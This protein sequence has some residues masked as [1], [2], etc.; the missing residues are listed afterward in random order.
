MNDWREKIPAFWKG[1]G[2]VILV[3]LLGA[4]LLLL[5]DRNTADEVIPEQN[6]QVEF[7]LA[8][9]EQRLSQALS[10]V[11]GAGETRVVLSLDSG[12]RTIL[13]QDRQQ[14]EGGATVETVTLG[15]RSGG[16]AV[17]PVQTMAPNFRGAVV[18][19]P[20]AE[21]PS[22]RLA[23]TRAVSVLTGLGADRICVCAGN[24]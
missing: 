17:V 2:P 13:A 18:V 1:R 11:S 15:E 5:P 14:S 23:L 8:E 24:S 6:G 9:F 3:M 7:E 20:G 12:N 19:S 4:F 10:R 21:N 22:V 16:E